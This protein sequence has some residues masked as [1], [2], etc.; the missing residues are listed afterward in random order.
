MDVIEA[1]GG[2]GEDPVGE[3]APGCMRMGF[4]TGIAPTGWPVG[5]KGEEEAAG[6]SSLVVIGAGTSDMDWYSG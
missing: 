1:T 4:D 6:L 3:G 2:E 5:G